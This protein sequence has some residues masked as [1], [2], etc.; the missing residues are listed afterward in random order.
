MKEFSILA[1]S[2][3]NLVILFQYLHL[4]GRN[5]IKPSLAMWT[6]FSLAVGMS[7]VTYLKVGNL[8]KTSSSLSCRM[9]LNIVLLL[10]Y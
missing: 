1:V 4:L 10:F 2:A 9:I 6:F 7:L 8:A 3:I 5:E